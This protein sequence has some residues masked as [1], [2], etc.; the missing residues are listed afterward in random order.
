MPNT[1]IIDILHFIDKDNK[2][3]IDFA[4]ENITNTITLLFLNK[5]LHTQS[6]ESTK[7]AIKNRFFTITIPNICQYD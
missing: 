5:Q 2:Q 4:N 1:S 7:E 6:M 3:Y